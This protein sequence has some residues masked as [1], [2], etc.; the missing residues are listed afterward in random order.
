MARLSAAVLSLLV[1]TGLAARISRKKEQSSS[2]TYLTPSNTNLKQV[3][4]VMNP[5]GLVKSNLYVESMK[6]WQAEA[7][8]AGISLWVSILDYWFNLPLPI[9][10]KTNINNGIAGMQ[11]Q[12]LSKSAPVYFTGHSMG[13]GAPLPIVKEL[14]ESGV[15]AG[16]VLQAAFLT[17]PFLPP[18]QSEVTFPGPT[19]TVGAELNYGQARVSRF[20]EAV[21]HQP[22]STHP[23]V[24]IE[25]MNHG[26]YFTGGSFDDIKPEITHAQAQQTQAKIVIDWLAKQLNLGSGSFVASEVA[27]TKKWVQPMIAAGIL[28]G[29]RSYNVPNQ[30]GT[31]GWEC[32][33][34]VCPQGSQWVAEAQQYVAGK[35]VISQGAQIKNN[36]ADL[37]PFAGG[38]REGRKPFI[39]GNVLQAYVM[40]SNRKGGLGDYDGKD[41]EA[42]LSP[43]T[44]G[45]L[46]VKMISRQYAGKSLL[47]RTLARDGDVCAELNQQ[48]YE[49]A[50]RNAGQK[51]RQRF[52]AHGQKLAFDATSYKSAGP[53][54]VYGKMEWTERDGKMVL[55]STG[56][57]TETGDRSI[58]GNHYCKLLSP[59]R[60][61]EWVYIEGLKANLMGDW[62]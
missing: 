27:R 35:D 31:P 6:Q 23:V 58:D 5:G 51:T 16:A 29:S 59:A 1:V 36:F 40:A 19:L 56:L 28:E 62:Q 7:E 12:G 2:F 54:W 50:L 39:Q 15:L 14:R 20:A 9:R 10:T 32:T 37:F 42:D 17:R 60:A 26:Q 8:S 61:M 45:E 24:I 53:L 33:R 21:Y 46:L 41:F 43:F 18:T 3:G 44:T 30:V 4:V 13:G 55:K 11:G 25:G 49:Y 38:D 47:G 52:E 57:F 22:E 48:A 34:G